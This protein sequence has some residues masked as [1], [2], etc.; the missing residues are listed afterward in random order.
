MLRIDQELLEGLLAERIDR[1]RIK[2]ET[3]R[4]ML[5]RSYDALTRSYELLAEPA[6]VVWHRDLP[7]DHP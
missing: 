6:P 4:D 1:H 7:K 3:T 2:D 5:R